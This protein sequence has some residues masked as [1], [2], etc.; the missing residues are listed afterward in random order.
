MLLMNDDEISHNEEL[1]LL[2]TFQE[3][4]LRDFP[5]PDRIGCPGPEFLRKLARDRKSVPIGDPRLTHVTR[6]SPCFRELM[7]IRNHSATASQVRRMVLAAAGV[8]CVAAVGMWQFTRL[9]GLGSGSGTYIAATLDLKD[10]SV[11]RGG[12]AAPTPEM[13]SL[14]LPRERLSLTIILPFASETG[15][16]EVK[17]LRELGQPLLTASGQARLKTGATLLNVRLNLTQITSGRYLVGIRR[18]PL[19]WTFHPVMIE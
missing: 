15:T 2:E 12:D 6:C 13:D 9:H 7:A 11:I 17:I 16:Y 1:R 8:V 10:R 18:V 14:R 5:N 4:A 19:D 3:A